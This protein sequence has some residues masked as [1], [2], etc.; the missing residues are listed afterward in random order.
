MVTQGDI[1][2]LESALRDWLVAFRPQVLDLINVSTLSLVHS[3]W[4]QWAWLEHGDIAAIPA[5]SSS[6]VT[7]YTVPDDR[8]AYL[9]GI[10]ADRAVGDNAIRAFQVDPPVGYAVANADGP[11]VEII[12]VVTSTTALFWPDPGGRFDVFRIF[13]G[14]ILME[15]GTRVLMTPSGQ[16]AVGST[17]SFAL[18]LRLTK[19]IRALAPD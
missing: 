18:R 13:P 12:R 6:P 3:D 16:G 4:G 1:R 19:L 7:I 10:R 5:A 14:P 11:D 8:R 15:P 17:Y 2:G 9:D